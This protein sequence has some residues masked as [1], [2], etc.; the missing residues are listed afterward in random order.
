MVLLI[1]MLGGAGYWFYEN[2]LKT[3]FPIVNDL[4]YTVPPGANLSQVAMDLMDKEILDYPSALTWVMLA[5]FQKRANQI[6]A[7]DY[8]VKVGITPQQFLEI[9]VKGKTTQH[10]FFE[11]QHSPTYS[12]LKICS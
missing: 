7:G 1:I 8:V 12:P 11:F 6:K 3:P 10:T 5:R 2:K 4:H 9:M